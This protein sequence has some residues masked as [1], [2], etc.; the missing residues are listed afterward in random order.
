MIEIRLTILLGIVLNSNQMDSS[1]HQKPECSSMVPG[2]M[3]R[4]VENQRSSSD[5]QVVEFFDEISEDWELLQESDT[6][7]K[8][9]HVSGGNGGLDLLEFGRSPG[10]GSTGVGTTTTTTVPSGSWKVTRYL[11][12]DK[13][14][15][16]YYT[17][18]SFDFKSGGVI[19]AT[20]GSTIIQ[21]SWKNI[22]DSGKSKMDFTFPVQNKF[23]ELND[24][25][26]VILQNATSIQLKN[27]SGGNGGT[28]YLDFGK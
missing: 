20:N 5:F 22:V 21:G 10:S 8:L 11:D 25:W 15:T 16:S 23:D 7:I 19:T 4:I 14:R 13:N 26:E 12:K 2:N 1:L 9:K 18:Y 27:V 6:S 3:L 28:S 24:D 17:G